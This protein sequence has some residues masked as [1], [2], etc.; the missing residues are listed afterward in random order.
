VK[1][2]LTAIALAGLAAIGCGSQMASHASSVVAP[3]TGRPYTLYTH[4]G[5]EWTKIDGTF[6]H[7]T[8]RLSDGN[9]NPPPGWGN[10]FQKG[11]LVFVNSAT[12]RFESAAGSV[13]FRR[14]ARARPP[15][16]CS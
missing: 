8:R 5:I 1:R 4:C 15:V 6:W 14:T 9:G 10:P 7:A 11:A 13:T 2:R 16:I 3:A 12:A